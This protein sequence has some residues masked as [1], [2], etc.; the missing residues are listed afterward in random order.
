[1]RFFWSDCQATFRLIWKTWSS[2]VLSLLRMPGGQSAS[3]S[4]GMTFPYPFTRWGSSFSRWVRLQQHHNCTSYHILYHSTNHHRPECS[5][6]FKTRVAPWNAFWVVCRVS[7]WPPQ[8][9]TI[10]HLQG[11]HSRIRFLLLLLLGSHLYLTHSVG[12]R[13]LKYVCDNSSASGQMLLFD[14]WRINV[15]RLRQFSIYVPACAGCHGS[16]WLHLK[17]AKLQ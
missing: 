6:M 15:F 1:M 2:L 5:T 4:G 7:R 17:H 14:L 13:V 16:S 10:S 11:C 3:S 8:L 12:A 9:L